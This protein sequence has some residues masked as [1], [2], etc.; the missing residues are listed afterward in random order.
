[1]E[2][3]MEKPNFD[4]RAFTEGKTA[5]IFGQ[6]VQ[7]LRNKRHLRQGCPYIKIGRS[8]RYLGS[9]IKAYLNKNRIVPER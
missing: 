1:M 5:E 7:T 3:L 9:D 4:D 6:S 2:V 8:V